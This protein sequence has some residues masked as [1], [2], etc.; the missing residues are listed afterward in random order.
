MRRRV[1]KKRDEAARVIQRVARRYI[2]WRERRSERRRRDSIA[3]IAIQQAFRSRSEVWR[4]KRELQTLRFGQLES[5]ALKLQR[6]TRRFLLK[7]SAKRELAHRRETKLVAD[8]AQRIAEEMTKQSAANEIQRAM[9]GFVARRRFQR[10]YSSTSSVGEGSGG[11][12]RGHE[13]LDGSS[14]G[15]SGSRGRNIARRTLV[16]ALVP[17]GGGTGRRRREKSVSR[18]QLK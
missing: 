14:S 17:G 9:R 6:A 13:H 18:F 2:G 16:S 10:Q 4:A 11:S 5:Y 12:G 15:R 7:I 3:A 1:L 8:E